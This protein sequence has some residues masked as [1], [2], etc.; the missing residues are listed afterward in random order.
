MGEG[1]LV[2][3]GRMSGVCEEAVLGVRGGCLD[4]VGMLSYHYCAL[5][6]IILLYNT[7]SLHEISSDWP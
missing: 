6:L 4:S 1:C 7:F 3:V 5:F 2:G